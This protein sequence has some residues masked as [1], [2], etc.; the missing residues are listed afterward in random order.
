MI[1]YE[2]YTFMYRGQ[3]KENKTKEVEN[4]QH[5]SDSESPG[6]YDSC[7]FGPRYHPRTK[8]DDKGLYS[9][10]TVAIIGT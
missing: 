9:F 8:S 5:L 10:T 1:N 6:T 4:Q 7:D 2:G 3:V